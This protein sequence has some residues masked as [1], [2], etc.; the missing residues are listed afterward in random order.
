MKIPR[1]LVSVFAIILL[2]TFF[3]PYVAFTDDYSQSLEGADAELTLGSTTLKRSEIKNGISLY[4]Y[5]RIYLLGG[6]DIGMSKDMRMFYGIFISSAAALCVL[7]LLCGIGKKPVLCFIL[8]AALT[9]CFAV[10]NW[11]FVSRGI[12]PGYNTK[13]GIAHYLFYPLTAVCG[14]SS[15]WLFITKR[16]YKKQLKAAETA[17]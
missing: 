17:E 11:D 1:L 7:L 15:I 16:K 13:W 4:T 3:L 8:A 6:D 12:V 5:A 10:L 9:A 2:G 14:I